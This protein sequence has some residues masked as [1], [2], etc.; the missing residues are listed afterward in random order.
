MPWTEK[1][2][3]SE[4][5]RFVSTVRADNESFS[6]VCRKFGISRKTGYKWLNRAEKEGNEELSDRRRGRPV[7][8][9]QKSIK[10]QVL[11]LKKHYPFWLKEET[12]TAE[13]K[14]GKGT[15]A[16]A[17]DGSSNTC[18]NRLS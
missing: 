2:A 14:I 11:K 10:A 12:G 4:R 3:R 5:A 16:I 13:P 7:G 18:R 15:A 8:A 17:F 1:S 9:D 6:L